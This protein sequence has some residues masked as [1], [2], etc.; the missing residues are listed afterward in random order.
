MS[1]SS[2]SCGN[3][4]GLM[5]LAWA[6]VIIGALNWL[7]VGVFDGWDL[8]A[9][10]FGAGSFLSRIIYI[11]VGLSGLYLLFGTCGSCSKGGKMSCG[12]GDCGS[13][14]TCKVEKMGDKMSAKAQDVADDMKEGVKEMVK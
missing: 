4:G 3:K 7:L 8:V 2:S 10:I 12:T 6:L 9:W 13:C 11:L 1:C 5:K 14:G